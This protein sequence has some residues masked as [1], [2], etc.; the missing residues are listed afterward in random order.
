MFHFVRLREEDLPMVLAWRRKPRVA[1]HMLTEVSGDME[2]H[3][4][5]FR[6]LSD[7]YWVIH[8]GARPIGVINK[9]G[10]SWGFYIGEDSAIALGGFVPPYFYNHVFKTQDRLYAD[11]MSENLGVRRLHE[12]HGYKRVGVKLIGDK[13]LV[14]LRLDRQEWAKQFAR[15]GHMVAEFE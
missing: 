15:Y 4:A 1:A 6:G 12:F 2:K 7:P 13:S 3:R 8:H 10:E 9:A 11:V 5:W 14:V